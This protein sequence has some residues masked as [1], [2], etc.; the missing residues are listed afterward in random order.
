MSSYH[1]WK[2]REDV[3]IRFSTL[4]C[5]SYARERKES[6]WSAFYQSYDLFSLELNKQTGQHD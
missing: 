5:N 4:L 1:K 6:S 3:G 2:A